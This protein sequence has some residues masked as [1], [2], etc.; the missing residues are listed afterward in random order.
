MRPLLI[1]SLAILPFV[2]NAADN[3]VVNGNFESTAEATTGPV[4]GWTKGDGAYLGVASE[5]GNRFLRINTPKPM[6]V[7][8]LQ[9]FDLKP[10]WKA[11]E[12]SARIRAKDVVLGKNAWD[13][14]TFQ[15]TTLAAD[16]KT[17]VGGKDGKYTKFMIQRD[18][19]WTAHKTTKEI[20]DGAKFL[21]IQC[22]NMGGQ[23]IGDFDDIVVTPI[24]K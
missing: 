14:V 22:W 17:I 7:M 16:G 24:L 19:D 18:Q 23:G 12:V 5:N 21:E 20:P 6:S 4:A 10:E 2:A 3:L 15:F 1:C 8:T 11:L 13:T 9:R